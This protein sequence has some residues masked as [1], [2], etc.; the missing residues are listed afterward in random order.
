MNKLQISLYVIGAFISFAGIVSL[1]M[2]KK[3]RY[4]R[5]T[6]STVVVGL[7]IMIGTALYFRFARE[8][9]R[10]YVPQALKYSVPCKSY[11]SLTPLI[12]DIRVAYQGRNII[13]ITITYINANMVSTYKFSK[14]YS[15]V[16]VNGGQYQNT[17]S[18]QLPNYTPT[19][20]KINILGDDHVYCANCPCEHNSSL[21]EI[22]NSIMSGSPHPLP[23]TIT[24]VYSNG[25]E[26]YIFSRDYSQV[27][28][29]NA[30]APSVPTS[31]VTLR[32]ETPIQ[33]RYQLPF[34]SGV[35]CGAGSGPCLSQEAQVEPSGECPCNPY[36]SGILDILNDII[37]RSKSHIN[38]LIVTY[39]FVH[40][41]DTCQFS[42]DYS[43]VSINDQAYIPTATAALRQPPFRIQV[44]TADGNNFVYCGAGSGPCQL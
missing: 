22:L 38:K 21:A 29:G 42:P 4:L 16:S 28:V 39:R 26:D 6:V 34:G 36:D 30:N 8:E 11:H 37:A 19:E 3:M 41:I 1:L 12:N 23:I 20:T 9:L 44:Q 43:Q 17:N 25:S 14:D 31:S 24:M 15:Q 33:V 35:H 13:S 40:L 5:Y 7:L 10:L 18:V 32:K 2:D 27:R